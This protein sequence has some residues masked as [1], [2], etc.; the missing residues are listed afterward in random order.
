M[1]NFE[2]EK[3]YEIGMTHIVIIHITIHLMISKWTW[4]IKIIY[5]LIVMKQ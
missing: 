2:I 3:N 1:R 4:I 5:T